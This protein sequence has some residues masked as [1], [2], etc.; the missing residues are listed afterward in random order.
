MLG[1]K[2]SV[3][4]NLINKQDLNSR[5]VVGFCMNRKTYLVILVIALGVFSQALWAERSEVDRFKALH[6]KIKTEDYFRP[7]DHAFYFDITGRQSKHLLRLIKEGEDASKQDQ[8]TVTQFLLRNMNTEHY[9]NVHAK[10]G[11]PLPRFTIKGVAFTPD[12]RGNYDLAASLSIT[13]LSTPTVFFGI[14]IAKN[15]PFIQLYIK[16]DQKYGLNLVMAPHPDW[17]ATMYMYYMKRWDILETITASQLINNQKVTNLDRAKNWVESVTAD[18]RLD[19]DYGDSQFFIAIE[20]LRIQELRSNTTEAGRLYFGDNVPLFRFQAQRDIAFD[21][22]KFKLF[23]G[24]HKRS[25]YV[26]GKGIY[27]GSEVYLGETPFSTLFMQDRE[28]L[29]FNPRFRW[30][31]LELEYI[32]KFP[33]SKTTD[34]NARTATLHGV[35]LRISI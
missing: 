22:W 5:E 1:K 14:L 8:A 6:D 33:T 18:F 11:F 2:K 10:L 24:I 3:S 25:G 34:G 19:Y 15:D 13:Q 17:E 9:G 35:N 4:Y 28:Y 20:E 23:T 7:I 31:F 16:N 29:T 12:I 21:W 30:K 32:G 27:L 26:P